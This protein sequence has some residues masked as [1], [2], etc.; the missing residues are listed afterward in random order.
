MDEVQRRK[1]L[2]LP[3]LEL[4]SFG[5][6]ARSQSLYRLR[7]PVILLTTTIIIIIIKLDVLQG[8]KAW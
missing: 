5:R 2:T 4:R 3:G 8:T 6:P 1:I 7:Y